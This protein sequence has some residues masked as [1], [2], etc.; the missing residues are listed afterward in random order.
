MPSLNLTSSPDDRLAI[1]GGTPTR[2]AQFLVEPMTGVEEEQFVLQALREKSFSRYIGMAVDEAVLRYTSAEAAALSD[3]WH[4]LGGPHVRAFAAD[5]A[6]AMQVPFAIPV[7][8]ATSG[9]SIALAAAGVG[10]GD[11]VIAPAISFSATAMSVLMFNSIPVFV[12]VDPQTFC[13]DPNAVE[14]AITPHTRA[15]MPVHLAGNI[16]DMN[17]L[18][19]IASKHDLVIIEDACQAIGGTLDGVKAGAI[20][21]AGVF[22]LQQSKNIMTGEGGMIITK[23]PEIAR[24]ARLIANHGELQFDERATVEDLANI[25]GFNFRMPELCAA[26][27][28]AQIAKLDRVNVWRTNNYRILCK[29]IANLPGLR[30]ADL[31]PRTIKNSVA[32]PHFLVAHYDSAT[33][34]IPRSI[35]VAALRAEGIPVGTGYSRPLYLNPTFTKKTAYGSKGSPWSDSAYKGN[36]SYSP[37]QCPVA[38]R[39]LNEEFLWFYHI[40]YSCTEDDMRDI[41]RAVRKVV[42]ARKELFAA[43][44][45]LMEKTHG[46]SAGRIGVDP[47]QVKGAKAIGSGKND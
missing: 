37:Q 17:A 40:A 44:P 46:H 18:A 14:R 19:A 26:V 7:S 8:S 20:G 34:G 23:N 11:E 33:M 15:I 3:Y 2:S 41:G 35:F 22:S 12:D 32:I 6:A 1:L 13:I 45:S 29:E 27:G 4:V 10:P 42:A 43:V 31:S 5:F 38:E 36:V 28:R 39:L 30:V 16:S 9:L 21:D 47:N 24:R 25:V